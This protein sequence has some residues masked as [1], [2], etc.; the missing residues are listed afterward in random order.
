MGALS[1]VILV[2]G[3]FHE[4]LPQVH[5]HRPVNHRDQEDEAWPLGADTAAQPEDHQPLV[6]PDDPNHREQE[7]QDNQPNKKKE[8][9]QHCHLSPSVTS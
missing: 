2:W 7:H 9:Q 4:L 6:L 3:D 8:D 1:L 5:H